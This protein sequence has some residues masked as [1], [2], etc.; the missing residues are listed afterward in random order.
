VEKRESKYNPSWEEDTDPNSDKYKDWCCAGLSIFKARCK[1]C[2]CECSV[3]SIGKTALQEHAGNV[4][5][6]DCR[7]GMI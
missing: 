1:W 7:K 3:A 4:Q 2:I 6:I 5:H